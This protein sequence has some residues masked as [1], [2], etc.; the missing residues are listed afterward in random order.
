MDI[1]QDLGRP[2]LQQKSKAALLA[3]IPHD[4]KWALLQND[5]EILF[6]SEKVKDIARILK[7]QYGFDAKCVCPTSPGP[8]RL[9]YS[10]FSEASYRY[11]FKQWGWT[12]NISSQKKDYIL[13]K[14]Q[15]RALRGKASTAVV[16]GFK[17][18]G[19]K[20]KRRAKSNARQ[21]FTILDSAYRR[22]TDQ[23][24]VF[25]GFV[26]FGNRMLRS[27]TSSPDVSLTGLRFLN[28]NLPL[29]AG[30]VKD[31]QSPKYAGI[32]SASGL[33]PDGVTVR[34]PS[35]AADSPMQVASPHDKPSPFST[36]VSEAM[37]SNRAS[38]F[39]HGR[40]DDLAQTMNDAE[41]VTI[42]T[43]LY[44]FWLYSFVTSKRWGHDSRPWTKDDLILEIPQASP[45]R[46]IESPTIE[47]YENRPEKPV[48]SPSQLCRWSI[49]IE[50]TDYEPIHDDH[51]GLDL[52]DS[53]RLKPQ[54]LV[55]QLR[56]AL[57]NND[58]SSIPANS[59]P[60]Q[61]SQ[62]IRAV[63]RSPEELFLESFSFSIMARNLLL[64]RDMLKKAGSK[65]IDVKSVYPLHVATSYLDG[66]SS[67][68]LILDALCV[69]LPKLKTFY[70]NDHGHTVLDNLMLT[71]LKGHSNTSPD[72]LDDTLPRNSRF[73]GI[74]VDLC[75]RWDA[76]SPCFRALL[77]SGRTQAPLKWKHKF[78]HT[79]TLAVCHCIDSLG[80]AGLLSDGESGLFAKRCFN[81]GLSLKLSPFHVLVLT[82]L[83][84]AQTGCQ[85]EDLFGMIAILLCMLANGLDPGT[86]V[87]ISIDLL[88]GVDD[89]IRCT[90]E[91]LTAIELAERLPALPGWTAELERGWQ[92]FCDILRPF[93]PT[94]TRTRG[95]EHL[96]ESP[97]SPTQSSD[98]DMSLN[99]PIISGFEGG[100]GDYCLECNNCIEFWESV[101][102]TEYD[103]ETECLTAASQF[104]YRNDIGHIWAA[105][106]TELLTYRRIQECEPWHSDHFD[107]DALHSGLHIGE[108]ISM[109]LL[110]NGMIKPYCRCGHWGDPW[111]FPT[112]DIV[113]EY[114]FGNL[115][116][117]DRTSF[118]S[119]PERILRNM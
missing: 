102:C 29:A 110:A 36:A 40:F 97:L 66:G 107:L 27:P 11:H 79:S 81:C 115:D 46:L 2:P 38:L 60:L 108:T 25:G 3:G 47:T 20:L 116:I 75:G 4:K 92:I 15:E 19:K 65:N 26:P 5:L 55:D 103:E 21:E 37:A 84:L 112:Q 76:D 114:Y 86:K 45:S 39:L 51:G 52:E 8:L 31:S 74:E 9:T 14:A 24:G 109:P 44:Q 88:V 67:C 56:D 77:E 62:I 7:Q 23:S 80:K 22:A 12:K 96:N 16:A 95:A 53:A 30:R 119:L 64:V 69:Q 111:E 82:T 18:E 91:E 6:H 41:K 59:L 118:L 85:D 72:I 35:V 57:E 73:A 34:T 90:H 1:D 42:S 105:F 58:F 70:T 32:F 98:Y 49:H 93:E 87:D 113:A 63:K 94:D 78:C 100:S 10:P 99:S 17:I 48:P 106:Q 117:W 33:T 28:W 43:W 68:C 83:Q 13:Q 71:I 61:P 54:P 89:G 50:E 101:G 104:E